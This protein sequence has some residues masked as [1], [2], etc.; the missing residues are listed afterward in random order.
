MMLAYQHF[1][2]VLLIYDSFFVSG[3]VLSVFWYAAMRMLELELEQQT[4]I[5]FLFKLGKSG[6]KIREM[7]MQVYR[8]NSIKKT[9]VYTW[10]TC[11]SVGSESVTDR[12]QDGQQQA[13]LKETLQK[14]VKLR[15][16]IVGSLSGA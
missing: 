5:K 2:A 3:V 8:Y 12:N 6:S 16:K 4:N 9:A 1:T 11:F 10:M 7:L 13:E 14:F 15:V